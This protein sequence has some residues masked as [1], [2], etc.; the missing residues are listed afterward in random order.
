MKRII[1]AVLLTLLTVAVALPA[2]AYQVRIG[3]RV[4]TDVF[5]SIMSGSAYTGP[6][7]TRDIR[8][9]DLTSFTVQVSD[10]ALQFLFYTDDRRTGAHIQISMTAGPAHGAT[11]VALTYMYGWY[12]FG[13]CRLDVGHKDTM[14]AAAKYAPYGALGFQQMPSG[15]GGFFEYGKL[16]SGRFVHIALYY[17]RP[18]W[19]VM[20]ALG[21]GG[22]NTANLPAWGGAQG[23]FVMNTFYPR[24]DVAFEYRHKYFSIGPGFMVYLTNWESMEG[25][26][27]QDDRSLTFAV[28]L[29]FRFQFGDFGFTGEISYGRNVI[30]PSMINTFKGG[31]W[32]GGG[33]DGNNRIKVAPTEL[34]GACLGFF[35]QIGRV[36]LWLSGGWERTVNGS[37]DAV[38]TWRHGQNTRYAFVFAAPY[39]VNRHFTIA[40]EIG[41]YFFGWNPTVDVGPGPQS[42]NA[43]LG[44]AWLMGIRISISF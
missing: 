7:N 4:S 6:A 24:L 16:Y 29:P 9:P 44:S 42:V 40:P 26:S 2:Q 15:S 37:S 20:V 19:S 28:A 25:I 5:Y 21:Q 13:N 3:G 30:V 38:G 36:T 34:F 22:Q 12:A 31:Q 33:N 41:Y 10:G 14:F 39:R 8:N 32:W 11:V 35:Y 27:L 1:G 17:N 23:G 18:A 43:D